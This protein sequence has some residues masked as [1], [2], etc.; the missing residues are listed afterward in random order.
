MMS[1]QLYRPA[2]RIAVIAGLAATICSC[3]SGD[4]RSWAF[5]QSGGG[6]KINAPLRSELGGWELQINADVSGTKEFS[7]KP[8][9][10]N[11]ALSCDT[12][13]TVKGNAIFITVFTDVAGGKESST[14]PYAHL[15]KL[16]PGEYSVSYLGPNEQPVFL[17]HVNIGST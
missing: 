3:A 11:S 16:L 1:P 4:P 5:V 17:G 6:L 12:S 9:K 15:G 14:C 13:A 7:T 2:R 8:T 10:L